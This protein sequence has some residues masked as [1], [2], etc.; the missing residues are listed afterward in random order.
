VPQAFPIESGNPDA[1]VSAFPRSR[2][3]IGYEDAKCLYK[4][5]GSMPLQHSD[6]LGKDR[7]RLGGKHPFDHSAVC[8]DLYDEDCKLT[9]KQYCCELGGVAGSGCST[10]TNIKAESFCDSL[11][12]GLATC[13]VWF[14][15]A[16]IL[17]G[18]RTLS[19]RSKMNQPFKSTCEE[20]KKLLTEL[21]LDNGK[22]TFFNALVGNCHIYAMSKIVKVTM[23]PTI[24]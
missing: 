16:K 5:V 11:S 12:L 20:D 10:C 13:G 18:E 19:P 15:P 2:D 7:Y 6:P 3:P 21:E 1:I 8:V 24:R 22:D 14:H 4:F 17:C 23:P 9:G